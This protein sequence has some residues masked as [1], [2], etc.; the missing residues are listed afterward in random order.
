[1]ALDTTGYDVHIDGKGYLFRE[2][3]YL[4]SK[5]PIVYDKFA[6]GEVGYDDL[7]DI[8]AWAQSEWRGG[9]DQKFDADRSRFLNSDNIEIMDSIGSFRLARK[10]VQTTGVLRGIDVKERWSNMW[11]VNR[12]STLMFSDNLTAWTQCLNMSAADPGD[13]IAWKAGLYVSVPSIKVLWASA[14]PSATGAGWVAELSS[15][16]N[17]AFDKL[18]SLQ[19]LL[20]FTNGQDKLYAYDGTGASGVLNVVTSNVWKI[21]NIES[22]GGR[23]YMGSVDKSNPGR[24][25]LRVYDGTTHTTVYEWTGVI[26]TDYGSSFKFMI[27]FNGKLYFPVNSGSP[28]QLDIYSFDG[29]TVELEL[30]LNPKDPK[31]TAGQFDYTANED[32]F[33]AYAQD[34]HVVDGKLFIT[35]NYPGSEVEPTGYT[36]LYCNPGNFWYRYV[37]FQT[38]DM[39]NSSVDTKI[40]GLATF[41]INKLGILTMDELHPNENTNIHIADMS[42]AFS[43]SG[44]IQSSVIDMDLFSLDKKVVTMEL[45]HDTMPVSSYVTPRLITFG[46]NGGTAQITNTTSGSETTIMKISKDNLGKKFQYQVDLSAGATSPIVQDVVLR[47][48]L[49]PN[50]KKSW[51]FELAVYDN[52]ELRNGET[53]SRS[54]PEILRDIERAAGKSVVSFR[55]VDGTVLDLRSKSSDNR[56]V[57]IR[58]AVARGPFLNSEHGPEYIVS[59]EL[60]EI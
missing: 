48:A 60:V 29:Q 16:V 18:A 32:I 25:A 54:A 27:P 7:S 45:Y 50:Y 21:L 52:M 36:E 5:K 19:D 57:L 34:A 2:G 35:V 12:Q 22:F 42:G 55:D 23:M 58:N 40:L 47:Y 24:I 49:E 17:I 8:P 15:S 46:A 1:M 9:F 3:T 41:F 10:F 26:G 20:Y 33:A 44:Q 31:N 14:N 30:S 38:S 43:P 56:G 28:Y 53:E 51:T 4:K 37:K 59:M 6:T 11:F 39:T 13:A